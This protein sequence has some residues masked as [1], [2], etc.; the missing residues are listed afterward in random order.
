MERLIEILKR[1]PDTTHMGRGRPR[2]VYSW[3]NVSATEQRKIEAL[4][5]EIET[6]I[7]KLTIIRQE[8]RRYTVCL[9]W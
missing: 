8:D 6:G 5:F 9:S 3:M 4:R 1:P 2:T 7:W